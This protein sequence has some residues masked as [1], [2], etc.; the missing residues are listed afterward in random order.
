MIDR[1]KPPSHFTEQVLDKFY[2][3]GGLLPGYPIGWDS[4]GIR[5]LPAELSIWAGINGHGKSQFLGQVILNAV[6]SGEKVAIASFE[7]RGEKLISRMARQA[8]CTNKPNRDELIECIEWLDEH[9]LIYDYVGRGLVDDMLKNFT[10]ALEAEGCT[11][12]VIDSLMKCGLAEDDYSGQKFLVEDFHNFAM[13]KNVHVHLVAHARKQ[14]DEND[15]PGKMSIAG[16]AGISNIADNI[17]MVWR[18]KGKESAFWES[19]KN[20]TPLKENFFQQPDAV[21]EC[22]K[23]RD[24]GSDVE[25][26]YWFWFDTDSLQY[27]DNIDAPLKRYFGGSYGTSPF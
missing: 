20:K 1:L 12:F 5:I 9:V 27:R 23:S 2:P 21:V 26:Q 17:Y 25:R 19:K 11:T 10:V 13:T 18:N 6:K 4:M 7:M 16:S 8:L 24:L 3:T 22:V 15:R 14:S